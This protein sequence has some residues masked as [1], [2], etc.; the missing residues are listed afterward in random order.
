M[1]NITLYILIGFLLSFSSCKVNSSLQVNDNNRT[2]YHI[3]KTTIAGEIHCFVP[4]YPVL[5]S[6]ENNPVSRI[7][8]RTTGENSPSSID[9]FKVD[10][11]RTFDLSDI[12]EVKVFYTAKEENFSIEKEFGKSTEISKRLLIS[13]QQDLLLGENNFWLSLTLN[14]SADLLNKVSASITAIK[15]GKQYKA[16][17]G[18]PEYPL[19]RTGIA[20][21]KHNDRGVDTYRIPGLATTNSGTLIAVYDIRRNS[22]VDLQ[23]DIDVGMNRSTDGGQTWEPMR[24]IMD[25]GEWG[26]LPNEQNGIGDPAVLVDRHTN[27]IWVAAV[28]AHGHPGKRNWWASKQGM[29][30]AETS[31]FVLVKSEDDG[32]TWSAPIN[33]TSQI[34]DPGWHL[35]L[36]GPGKGITLKDGT[37]V[38]PAQFKDENEM[39]HSTLIYSKDQGQ[40]W[41]IGTGAKSNTTEAQIVELSDGALMLNMRDNRGSGPTG[42]NGKG[43]RSV[44]TTNDLGKTW[45]EHPTSMKALPEP[46]CMASL[47]RHDYTVGG[48]RKSILIFSN[49]FDQYTRQ[50]MTIKVSEDEGM[51]WQEKYFTLIDEGRGRGYSCLTSIDE[52]TIG[53]LYEG[54]QADLVFQKISLQEL[55]QNN[56]K[57]RE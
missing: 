11:S 9:G 36:Q 38:F 33:I 55:M 15:T 18:S 6:K 57:S 32:K 44:A 27:T 30:P 50:N 2:Q 17:S 13:G 35:L 28:W 21:R 48:Q 47:I 26:D 16:I 25:M 5:R 56:S 4:I 14:E 43:A 31:Q 20:L 39:P 40:C 54:S 19:Q 29:T 37:L 12:K 41:H 51:T 8:I 7:N 52:N 10:L 23:E 53:I 45:V 42:R 34:K 46:V 24:I 22:A 3:D 1:N 49:P